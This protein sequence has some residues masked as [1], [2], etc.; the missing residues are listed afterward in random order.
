MTP[1]VKNVGNLIDCG[2]KPE[3]G[4]G[5]TWEKCL[6]K[7]VVAGLGEEKLTRA[8]AQEV[9]DRILQGRTEDEGNNL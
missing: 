4:D 2:A 6:L 8:G 1:S 5:I 7:K 9:L 3:P